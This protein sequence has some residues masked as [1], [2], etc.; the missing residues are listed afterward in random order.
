MQKP[1]HLLIVI[2]AIAICFV[3]CTQ[4]E[5]LPEITTQEFPFY[6]EYSVNGEVFVIEDTIICDFNGLIK[7]R[8]HNTSMRRDWSQK[9]KSTNNT[10]TRVVIIK[11]GSKESIFS[12]RINSSSR[13]CLSL[14]GAEYYMGEP[15]YDKIEKPCFYYEEY[16][17]HR[18]GPLTSECTILTEEQLKE[19]F[20]IEIIQFSFSPPVENTFK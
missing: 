1:F 13:I 17:R 4:D 2:I 11:E 9:L 15:K 5:T 7:G 16:F 20:N 6:V 14:G 18:T 12:D 19:F 8:G 3:S 10:D